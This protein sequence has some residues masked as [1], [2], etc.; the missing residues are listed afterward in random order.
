M[1]GYYIVAGGRE[2]VVRASGDG[3]VT[4]S[5]AIPVPAGT[6]RSPVGGELAGSADGRHFVVVVS[7]GGDLPGVADVTLFR[8]AVSVT[9]DPGGWAS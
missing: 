9:A 2:V 3:H 8:L 5:V 1:P 7:R 4:G 6:P